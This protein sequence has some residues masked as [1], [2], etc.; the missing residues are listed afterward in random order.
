VWKDASI[1]DDKQ[2]KQSNK[3]G[4]LTFAKSGPNTRT[5]Q[6]F[7]NYQDNKRLD[8]QGFPPIGRV[9]AGMD[10]IEAINQEYGQQ[11]EQAMIQHS[12]NS[13]LRDIFPRLDYIKSV[14]LV[15]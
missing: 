15:Q 12:G 10:V 3:K 4:T 7:V 6:L 13:Y 2:S 5:T 8:E 9:T 14:T 1:K 11:P